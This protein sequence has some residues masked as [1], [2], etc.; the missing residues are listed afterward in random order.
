MSIMKMDVCMCVLHKETRMKVCNTG[1]INKSVFR[2]P[3]HQIM[4]GYPS[5]YSVYSSYYTNEHVCL[6]IPVVTVCIAVTIQMSMY[7]WLSQRL[8]CV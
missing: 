7:V 8:Q 3:G 4:S 2:L 1:K 5:G 6:A